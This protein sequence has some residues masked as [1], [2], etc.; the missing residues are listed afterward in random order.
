MIFS[1]SA[2]QSLNDFVAAHNSISGAEFMI[3]FWQGTMP[4][5]A[6]FN[7]KFEDD[8]N[9]FSDVNP[10]RVG[11]NRFYQWMRDE[12]NLTELCNQ[13][14]SHNEGA[15][16]IVQPLESFYT[17]SLITAA[18]FQQMIIEAEGTAQVFSCLLIDPNASRASRYSEN[19]LIYKGLF[20]TLGLPESGADQE[21]ADTNI[22]FESTVLPGTIRFTF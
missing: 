3:S 22:T 10:G 8:F 15:I 20:G 21:I 4:T 2:R 18:E 14:Y 7:T 9:D 1:T 17:P 6:D 19:R 16:E 13:N 12:Q 5:L 11:I